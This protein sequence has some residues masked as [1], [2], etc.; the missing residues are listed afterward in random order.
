MKDVEEGL[1][2]LQSSQFKKAELHFQQLLTSIRND[3]AEVYYFYATAQAACALQ[4]LSSMPSNIQ[5][6]Q[7]ML[8]NALGNYGLSRQHSLIISPGL[9][10][11]LSFIH[12]LQ[13]SINANYSP[14]ERA[15][16]FLE[17][18]IEFK[19]LYL[20]KLNIKEQLE[21]YR[22][23][24]G[25]SIFT[26]LWWAPSLVK[27]LE[28]L[29]DASMGDCLFMS[30]EGINKLYRIMLAHL[31]DNNEHTKALFLSIEKQLLSQ[32]GGL[33][34]YFPFSIFS[35]TSVLQADSAV[36][37]RAI[38]SSDEFEK[39]IRFIDRL[40]S[41]GLLNQDIF[42]R[43]ILILRSSPDSIHHIQ[44]IA[45]LIQIKNPNKR[46]DLLS[47]FFSFSLKKIPHSSI[48]KWQFDRFLIDLERIYN[49][50][51]SDERISKKILIR[52]K[53]LSL[54][55]RGELDALIFHDS[56]KLIQET[57]E[58]LGEEAFETLISKIL[59]SERY[60]K[61]CIPILGWGLQL[62]REFL[63][64]LLKLMDQD[65]DWE[66]LKYLMNE[67]LLRAHQQQFPE[68]PLDE[69]I[70]AFKTQSVDVQ[71]TLSEEEL[72][73]LK[74]RY[75][76]IREIGEQ[77]VL[78]GINTLPF[79]LKENLNQI[80][81][82]PQE[83]EY[84]LRILA[85][86]RAQIKEAFG[87]FPY[88]VQMI[89]LLALLNEPKRIAQI[90]T[91]EGKSTLIAMLASFYALQGSK[92]DVV[93][94]SRDLAVR[95]AKKFESFY[96]KLGLKV[97]HNAKDNGNSAD[98]LPHI[99]YGTNFDF[100][101]AY[102]RGETQKEDK[103]RGK[104]GYDVVIADEVD[105]MFIDM[106]H[107]EA[108][109]SL[110]SNE[111]H[112]VE[113]YQSIWKWIQST[114]DALVTPQEL[115]TR[116]R[117]LAC[118]VSLEQAKTWIN[119]ARRAARYTEGKH[120]V[121]RPRDNGSELEVQIV[122][123]QNTGQI[124]INSRWQDG[125]HCFL[126]AKH[127]LNI[128]VES[129]TKASINH[130]EFF[131]K[132]K[133]LIGLTGT[134]GSESSR[135]ELRELYHVA[136][137]D[138]PSYRLSLKKPREHLVSENSSAQE[139]QILETVK[140]L[141]DSDRPVLIICE[142]IKESEHL[143]HLL[144]SNKCAARLYNGIQKDD[145]D[146]IIG[147]AG[148]PG[149]VTIATNTA[150][151]GTDIIVTPKAEAKGGLHVIMTFLASNVRVE[152]QA[153]GRTGRQ[154]RNGSY[155]YILRKEQFSPAELLQ[156]SLE[157]MMSLMDVHREQKSKMLSLDNL[158]NQEVRHVQFQLQ[159][160]FFALPM[161]LKT[162]VMSSWA[163]LKT[164]MQKYITKFTNNE[165][166]DDETVV[167]HSLCK[168]FLDFWNECICPFSNDLYTTPLHF[169]VHKKD[170][171]AVELLQ[172]HLPDLLVIKNHKNQSAEDLINEMDSHGF[173]MGAGSRGL[174]FF[175]QAEQPSLQHRNAAEEAA[176]SLYYH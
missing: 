165:L 29:M 2:Y 176:A 133:I 34:K 20:T 73:H 26:S 108:I 134:L 137:Y 156:P 126:E 7:E 98:Y 82:K 104:R 33:F 114:E 88:N 80:K 151:R 49:T 59:D 103:G 31:K 174:V 119:S 153:F 27:E 57:L 79:L 83:D 72:M 28:G 158:L 63:P 38:R 45:E 110:E 69:V 39:V 101:F 141:I 60:R 75:E 70:L 121:I 175:A 128:R 14:E 152:Q 53:V 41:V 127:N 149:A 3:S 78:D 44:H 55:E 36:T 16:F 87:I 143:H 116:I 111:T 40:R 122:D 159:S 62:R 120:Y 154:G 107:N 64:R 77:I 168:Q 54:F 76:R 105:S 25:Q 102:L 42:N 124:N 173:S 147:L 118:D 157:Q 131:N 61:H 74:T 6:G 47:C 32:E 10:H 35:G 5:A 170:Y 95:D 68:K 160:L 171:E 140:E 1:S 144:S 115:Q 58:A 172:A 146:T 37:L 109:I 113:V 11:A 145:S 56:F 91:G 99:V 50:P 71:F 112:A 12:L 46:D 138:S 117:P 96:Q 139:L 66:T 4:K 125:V 148:N 164:N 19:M 89:N 9:G 17:R 92:V 13:D 30:R 93:T 81:S 51:S 136:S 8:A 167:I 106:Q 43:L 23:R 135:N 162:D 86:I 123:F 161:A 142:T 90:K 94:T 130:I 129:L 155:H 52:L 150:G 166:I 65:N 24:P 48:E 22:K 84:R 85:I 163:K 18:F 100:E 97:G 15:A 21:Q 132:Y 169:A 67:A